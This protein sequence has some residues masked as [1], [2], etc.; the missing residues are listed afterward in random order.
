MAFYVFKIPED[1]NLMCLVMDVVPFVAD[2]ED[3]VYSL[4]DFNK[5]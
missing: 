3:S 5:L 4:E 2:R 1:K